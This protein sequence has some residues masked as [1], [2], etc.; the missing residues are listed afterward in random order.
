[1]ARQA[2]QVPRC[3]ATAV[4]WLSSSRPRAASR[5]SG[6]SSAQVTSSLTVISQQLAQDGASAVEARLDGA[7]SA[8]QQRRH[9]RLAEALQVEENDQ[10]RLGRQHHERGLD[11][12]SH[13]LF[14]LSLLDLV[15]R[16]IALRRRRFTIGGVEPALGASIA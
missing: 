11:L 5:N 4:A 12:V 3:A 15:L 9:L 13:H 7:R 1:M 8:A 2:A 10:A 6:C 16:P 14:E